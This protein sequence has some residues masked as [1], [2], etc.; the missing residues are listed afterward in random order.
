ML[1]LSFIFTLVLLLSGCNISFKSY[2]LKKMTEFCQDKE[3]IHEIGGNVF[4]G[5][6]LVDEYIICNDGTKI[7]YDQLK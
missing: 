1:R 6:T 3:G 5:A 2:D 4:I 7:R